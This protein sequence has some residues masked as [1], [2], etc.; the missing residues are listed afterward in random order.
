MSNEQ[1][2][3]YKIAKEF[4]GADPD[5]LSDSETIICDA[6]VDIEYLIEVENIY[7][8]KEYLDDGS[9]DYKER[10]EVEYGVNPM[11]NPNKSEH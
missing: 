7:Q 10:V 3:L 1:S 6:L 4:D 5:C 8:E 11:K 9:I 2:V